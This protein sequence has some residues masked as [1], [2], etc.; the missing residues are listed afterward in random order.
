[1]LDI[2][3]CSGMLNIHSTGRLWSHTLFVVSVL[4]GN[5]LFSVLLA[6]ISVR[7]I[8]INAT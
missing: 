7:N 4:T 1:M 8:H 5:C 2:A 3:H 6:I